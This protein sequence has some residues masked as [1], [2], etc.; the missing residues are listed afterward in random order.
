MMQQRKRK[1][2][3]AINKEYCEEVDKATFKDVAVLS[4]FVSDRG[5]ILGRDRTGLTAKYQRK[6]AKLIKQARHLGLLPFVSSV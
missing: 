1:I 2:K 5:R 6:V 4:K 3:V